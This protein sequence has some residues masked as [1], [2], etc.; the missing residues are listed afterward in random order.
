MTCTGNH[1]SSSFQKLQC[2]PVASPPSRYRFH[3]RIGYHESSH[4]RWPPNL[5]LNSTLSLRRVLALTHLPRL[6]VFVSLPA[7]I[8]PAHLRQGHASNHHQPNWTWFLFCLYTSDG[9]SGYSS[10]H[11]GRQVSFGRKQLQVLAHPE[12]TY[13]DLSRS[14]CI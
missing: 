2:R 5:V 7:P 6:P 3:Y 1:F 4:H 9:E 10:R 12:N 13:A 8:S 11:V 14:L